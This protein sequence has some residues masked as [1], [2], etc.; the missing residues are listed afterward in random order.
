MVMETSLNTL[1]DDVALPTMSLP[2]VAPDA[3]KLTQ[4]AVEEAA[5]PAATFEAFWKGKVQLSD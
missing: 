5:L 4:A 1:P 2:L 3:E